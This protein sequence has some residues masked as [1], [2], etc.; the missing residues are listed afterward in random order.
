MPTMPRLGLCCQCAEQAIKYRTTTTASS[1]R[2][3]PPDCRQR[4]SE[5]SLAQANEFFLVFEFCAAEQIG[6]SCN[7]N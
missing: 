7:V 3:T 4:L 5:L 1:L 2:V 6:V